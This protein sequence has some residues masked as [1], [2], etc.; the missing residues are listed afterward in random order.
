MMKEKIEKFL[1]ENGVGDVGFCTLNPAENP[2]GLGF[3]IS[4][5]IPL[6]KSVVDG[7]DNAPTHTYFHHYRTVN[8]FIDNISL[9][10][11]LMLAK[12]GFDYAAIPASQSVNGLQ[13]IFSHKYAA[14]LSG[15]GTIG[16]S[17]LFL[18]RKF[19]PGVRLGTI[20]T[21]CPFETEN[22]QPKSI[23]GSCRICVDSCPAMAIR[24]EEWQIGDARDKIV[25]AK[26]CSD[27]M[28]KEFQ[29]IGRGVVCGICMK[30]CP[31]RQK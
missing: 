19:G 18:S 9:K 25:D 14:T 22:A 8:T 24:G 26:A 16:K 2:F 27:Y 6:S 23:C 4:F 3:A 11:G 29:H 20:L 12:E 1:T 17:G 31:K 30:V 21:D 7:I 10:V 15:L 13:G 5:A 28:K